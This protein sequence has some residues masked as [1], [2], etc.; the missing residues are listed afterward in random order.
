M[1]ADEEFTVDMK[2]GFQK[3]DGR[4]RPQ[5]NRRLKAVYVLVIV[6]NFKLDGRPN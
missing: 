4:D 1:S 3:K 5:Y 6:A 2:W